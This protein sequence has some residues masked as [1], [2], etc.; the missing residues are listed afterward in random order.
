MLS[1]CTKE[2]RALSGRDR[3]ACAAAR[4]RENR[5]IA[6]I[7]EVLDRYAKLTADQAGAALEKRLAHEGHAPE[8]TVTTLKKTLVE[9]SQALVEPIRLEHTSTKIKRCPACIFG[10]VPPVEIVGRFG[11]AP[12]PAG[13]A[14]RAKLFRFWGVDAHSET[15]AP[16]AMPFSFSR[17][18]PATVIATDCSGSPLTVS[19]PRHT[20]S[21]LP[22][23][24]RGRSR[25]AAERRCGRRAQRDGSGGGR[26]SR[27]QDC[28]HG[29]ILI[30]P[31]TSRP[32]VQ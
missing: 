15:S 11:V 12:C 7:N 13:Q 6:S 24:M 30:G 4:I 17:A 21:T 27:A 20:A 8:A 19:H 25:A 22:G 18:R 23:G 9:R 28:L 14:I 31:R 3:P 1:S 2:P 16:H 32:A 26:C 10:V 29:C 5:L